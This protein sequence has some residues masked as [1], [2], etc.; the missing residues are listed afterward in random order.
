MLFEV[1]ILTSPNIVIPYFFLVAHVFPL[2]PSFPPFPSF[3]F[4]TFGSFFISPIYT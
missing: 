1:V 2:R 3:P 4:Y